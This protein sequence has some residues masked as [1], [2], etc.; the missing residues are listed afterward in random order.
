MI[1]FFLSL[2]FINQLIACTGIQ[3]TATDNSVVNGRT[4]EFGS[5]ID[6]YPAVIPRNYTFT[7]KSST[8]AGLVYKSKYAAVGMYCFDY[9]VLMD[10]M[11]EKGLS[12]GAFYFPGYAEYAT[13]TKKNQSKSL[14]PVEFPN[15]ILTQFA[16]IDEVKEALSSIAIAPTIISSWGA[17]PAPFHYIVYDQDG[18]SI[19]IEPINGKLVVHDT[20]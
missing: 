10:G 17:V 3:I 20:S 14:S 11:N 5:V 15:W 2:I 6:M 12:A 18:R 19:V 9:E 16:T 1:K 8:G 13:I 7:G 4:V